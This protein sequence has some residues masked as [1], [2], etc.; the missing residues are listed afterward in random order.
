MSAPLQWRK[1]EYRRKFSATGPRIVQTGLKPFEERALV[2]LLKPDGSSRTFVMAGVVSSYRLRPGSSTIP[3][4]ELDVFFRYQFQHTGDEVF[5]ALLLRQ[6]D[7]GYV[8]SN[9]GEFPILLKRTKVEFA[10]NG[11]T[12]RKH[13][14]FTNKGG[15]PQ[16]ATYAGEGTYSFAG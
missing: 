7:G 8:V 9:V 14:R 15:I 12:E 11:W 3:V 16:V 4:D 1:V 5:Y 10:E 2:T 6:D 13:L